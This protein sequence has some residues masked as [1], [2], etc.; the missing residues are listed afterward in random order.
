MIHYDSL[1]GHF[2][3]ENRKIDVSTYQDKR[4]EIF[5]HMSEVSRINGTVGHLHGTPFSCREQSDKYLETPEIRR[6]S[7]EENHT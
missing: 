3:D 4:N 5:E 6:F 1:K 2:G 7:R